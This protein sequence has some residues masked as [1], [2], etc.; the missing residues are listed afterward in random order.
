MLFPDYQG[1][2][3]ANLMSSI[4]LAMGGW[5]SGYVPLAGLDSERLGGVRNLVLLVV[6]GL[7]YQYLKD[8][9]PDSTLF[10]NTVGSITSVCPST[11]ASAI[12]TFLSGLPPQQHGLTGW[13]TYFAEVGS[14]LTILPYTTRLGRMPIDERILHPRQLSGVTP[15]YDRLSAESHLVI[16]DWIAGSTFNRAFTGQGKIR[17]YRGGMQGMFKGIQGAVNSAKGRNFIYAYWPEFDSLAHEHGVGS[18]EVAVHLKTLDQA[19]AHMTERLRGTDTL[20]LVTAD[21]GFVD[22]EPEHTLRL[23]DHPVLADTLMMPLCGEPRLAFCYVHPDR[24]D[25]FESYVNQELGEATTLFSSEQLL[26]EGV[27]GLGEPHPRLH[28]RIGHYALVMKQN[29]ILTS[30]MPGERPLSH[31]GVHGGLSSNEMHVPLISMDLTYDC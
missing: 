9:A 16:P 26:A 30:E 15:I 10:H 20:V 1:G 8:Q 3:I 27:F 25:A 28:D 31:I 17:P 18:S 14:V 2:S 11:T 13:F 21:H 7:G 19:F 6:D 12:P 24:K 4:A 22:T 23:S 5:E 29:Y